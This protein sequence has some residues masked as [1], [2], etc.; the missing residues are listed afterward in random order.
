MKLSTRARWS[1]RKFWAAM[2][3]QAA[4]TMLLVSGKLPFDTYEALTYLI[5]GGY[6]LSNVASKV[7]KKPSDGL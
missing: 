7:A 5:L 4:T 1:S 6:F 2:F 3:W